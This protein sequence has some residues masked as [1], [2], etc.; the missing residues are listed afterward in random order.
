[1]WFLAEDLIVLSISKR[2]SVFTCRQRVQRMCVTLVNMLLLAHTH[3][4]TYVAFSLQSPEGLIVHC[5]PEFKGGDDCCFKYVSLYTVEGN[6]PHQHNSYD[7]TF[8]SSRRLFSFSNVPSFI[9]LKGGTHCQ[10][11]SD[12]KLLERTKVSLFGDC[13]ITSE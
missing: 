8:S 1:M 4:H 9:V 11:C 2:T 6:V 13:V 12:N 3:T 10:N 5:D 7:W